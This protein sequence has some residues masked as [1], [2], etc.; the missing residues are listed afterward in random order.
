MKL[1]LS[2]TATKM[3]GALRVSNEIWEKLDAIARKEKVS[4]QEIIRA[5]LDQVIDDVEL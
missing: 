4:V 2:K 1:R 3:L 5:I